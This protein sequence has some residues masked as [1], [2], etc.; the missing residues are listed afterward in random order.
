MGCPVITCPGTTYPSRV[1]GT[2]LSA[3]EMPELIC[4]NIQEY[5]EKVVTL[6]TTPGALKNLREK[7]TKKIEKSPLFNTEKFTH[8]FE[9]AVQEMYDEC[10]KELNG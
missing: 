2:L 4:K 3:L 10:I 1:G 7:V 8:S 5:E 9:Q 6:C